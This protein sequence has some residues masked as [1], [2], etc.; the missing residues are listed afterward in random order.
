MK[1]KNP[2]EFEETTKRM[3]L[4]R[5]L[6]LHR[7]CEEKLVHNPKRGGDAMLSGDTPLNELVPSL[8]GRLFTH[9]RS[10]LHWFSYLLLNRLDGFLA[11]DA[12]M[13]KTVST[14]SFSG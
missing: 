4:E 13:G 2:T 1:E 3:R 5:F 9:Q 10:A 14:I 12:G 11:D 6:Q 7:I 8:K